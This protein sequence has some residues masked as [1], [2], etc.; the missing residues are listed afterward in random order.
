MSGSWQEAYF[1][2]TEIWQ[3]LG[4]L[5]C[6]NP[7]QNPLH[8]FL[9]SLLSNFTQSRQTLSDCGGVTAGQ[10]WDRLRAWRESS[11]VPTRSGPAS[12][13]GRRWA[14][15]LDS[16][17]LL[18][19]IFLLFRMEWASGEPGRGQQGQP[20]PWEL[21]LGLLLSGEGAWRGPRLW[22]MML[23]S[24]GGWQSQGPKGCGYL[25]KSLL[26]WLTHCPQCW[27]PHW[28]SPLPWM[29]LAVLEEAAIQPLVT[30]WWAVRTD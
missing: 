16:L 22:D 21:R 9:P 5:A 23:R 26:N 10:T 29:Y 7:V 25:I 8:I 13:Q 18:I 2:S 6:Y 30:C 24:R 11:P 20:L 1:H 3:G 27:L 19:S 15:S 17:S 28:P 4:A 14:S 12:T